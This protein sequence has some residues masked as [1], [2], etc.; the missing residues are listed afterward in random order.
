MHSCCETTS[1]LT[2]E[3]M[4]LLIIYVNRV[5]VRVSAFNSFSIMSNLP[6]RFAEKQ[7]QII[8]F[9]PQICIVEKV[10]DGLNSAPFSLHTL[11]RIF[12][13]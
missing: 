10:L 13:P 8:K 11:V 3:S 7:S 12:L 6:T 9:Q 5:F 4:E 2:P 1:L